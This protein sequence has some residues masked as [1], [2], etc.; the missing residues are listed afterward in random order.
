MRELRKVASQGIPDGAGIRSTVWKVCKN[1]T[2]LV[3]IELVCL[4]IGKMK[5]ERKREMWVGDACL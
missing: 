4:V 3:L 1:C 5:R 2:F